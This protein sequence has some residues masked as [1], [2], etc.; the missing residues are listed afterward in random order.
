MKPH[1]KSEVHILSCK[2]EKAAARAVQDGQLQQIGKQENMKN[3]M[4]IKAFI[5][6]TDFLAHRHIPH[7]TNFD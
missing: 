4:A 1:V 3:R 7:L 6:C 2:V 5:Q